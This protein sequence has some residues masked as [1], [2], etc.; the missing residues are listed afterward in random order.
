MKLLA[1]AVDAGWSDA[2]AVR[3][4]QALDPLRDRADFGELAALV[5]A[6]A[7]REALRARQVTP[8]PTQLASQRRAVA[9]LSQRAPDQSQ[10]MEHQRALAI[11][12]HYIGVVQTGIQAWDDAE[13]SLHLA[14]NILA[15]LRTDIGD[16]DTHN[17]YCRPVAWSV[18]DPAAARRVNRD[19]DLLCFF[20]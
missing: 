2:A 9:M 4:Y 13:T 8:D 18:A 6:K 20:P 10:H 11:T 1:Q 12:H 19:Q 5:E 14:L 17:E 7:E 3:S 16:H 15:T